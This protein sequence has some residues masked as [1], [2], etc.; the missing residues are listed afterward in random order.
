MDELTRRYTSDKSFRLILLPVEAAGPKQ[1]EGDTAKSPT[2]DLQAPSSR[3]SREE[4]YQDVWDASGVTPIFIA[5]VF[6][7]TVVAAAGLLMDNAPAIIG[8]MVIAPLLGPNAGLA[9]AAVLADAKLMLR[10]TK[11]NIIGFT[12]AL[13]MAYAIGALAPMDSLGLELTARTNASVADM[14]IALAAGIAGTIAFTSPVSTSLIG[15]M[16]AVALLPPTV[17]CGMLAGAGYWKEAAGA[18]MLVAIN[19]TCINLAGVATFVA[20]GN[21]AEYVVRGRT[22]TEKQHESP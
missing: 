20:Q 14:A 10:S 7:S 6:L 13:A 2:H 16:V 3:I 18:M 9:L 17:A 22:C 1:D 5:S 11:G 15:V 8:A 19:D 21:S 12:L 4:L